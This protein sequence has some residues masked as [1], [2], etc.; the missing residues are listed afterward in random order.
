[1]IKPRDDIEKANSVDVDLNFP[2]FFSDWIKLRR[3]QLDL[4]QAELAERAC[5]SVFALRKIEAGER[6]PSKQLAGMLAKALEIREE[7]HATFIKVARGELGIEKLL[8]LDHTSIPLAAPETLK[9]NL[10]RLLTPFVG[11]EPELT[12]LAGLL[13]DPQCSLLT[14][15]GPGGIGKTRLAIEAARQSS[16]LFPGGT[17]F[18]PLVSLNSPDLIVSAIAD[19]LGF[20]FQDPTNLQEQL[21]RY[22]HL[23]KAL[24]VLDNAEHLVAGAGVLGELLKE[25]PQIK[26][27]V[28]SQARLNLLSEW[29]FDIQ[30][31]PVPQNNQAKEITDFS[32]VALFLQCGRRVQADFMLRDED[33]PWVIKI[34]QIMEGMPL[35]IE[36]SSAWISLLTCEEIAK[37]IEQSLDFLSVSMGDLPERHRSIRATLEHSWKLLNAEERLILCRL[38]VFRG[39]FSRQAAQA[40]CGASLANLSSLK[41]KSL[42]Y[43]IDHSNYGLHEIIR[44]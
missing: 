32:S 40:V 43:R 44:Q 5:C 3:K 22:L 14:I 13:R 9:G 15:V 7:D 39:A 21:F 12:A 18:I 41:H 20:K 29:V 11:R 28:T 25:C 38:S 33:R 31:L 35:G 24:L 16:D 26:L 30:G 36:L 27:V 17:W 23:K 6:R 10:P 37:E 1:L 8:V 19:G 42:R 4:T 34:C 2:L